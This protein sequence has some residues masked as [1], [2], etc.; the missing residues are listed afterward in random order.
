VLTVAQRSYLEMADR[1][2]LSPDAISPGSSYR[3]IL[4][5]LERGLLAQQPAEIDFDRKYVVTERG[6]LAL[7]ATR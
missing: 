5:L 2:G 7:A 4:R 1:G 6:R 3:C